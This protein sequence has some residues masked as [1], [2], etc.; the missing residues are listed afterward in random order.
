M[1]VF[2][3]MKMKK[4]KKDENLNGLQRIRYPMRYSRIL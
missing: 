4:I 2:E 3:R 1:T